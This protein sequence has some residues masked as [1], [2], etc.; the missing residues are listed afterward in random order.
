M[1]NESASSPGIRHE[2]Y[3]NL[4]EDPTSVLEVTKA[5]LENQAAVVSD[6][7]EFV[8]QMLEYQT[9]DVDDLRIRYNESM[10][11]HSVDSSI[12]LEGPKKASYI[13]I[14]GLLNETKSS[15]TLEKDTPRE[16]RTLLEMAWDQRTEATPTR[17]ALDEVAS[18]SGAKAAEFVNKW[19][20]SDSEAEVYKDFLTLK[21]SEFDKVEKEIIKAT[22]DISRLDG[23][24]AVLGGGGVEA[25]R[26]KTE[27]KEH[28]K[29]TA[30]ADLAAEAEETE[31]WA[32]EAEIQK[33]LANV[34][35]IDEKEWGKTEAR[36]RSLY[37]E[38]DDINLDLDDLE[39][40]L[41]EANN[42]RRKASLVAQRV[43]GVEFDDIPELT[44]RYDI[45]NLEDSS[46]VVGFLL[47]KNVANNV[48]TSKSE[49]FQTDYTELMDRY[50]SAQAWS[51]RAE[52]LPR[53][54]NMEKQAKKNDNL[55][56]IV[57]HLSVAIE[58]LSK[59]RALGV[60]QRL[61]LGIALDNVFE[62]RFADK[63]TTVYEL[64][65]G[66]AEKARILEIG[67]RERAR[68][69]ELGGR[70]VS[71]VEKRAA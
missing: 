15:K 69:R 8:G 11:G 22:E 58:L 49:K 71:F 27:A 6:L 7:E 56:D 48:A 19:G 3:E 66:Q 17:E 12:L 38:L 57:P 41:D 40:V 68:F 39:L 24:R 62:M 59:P 37:P 18:V 21:E 43:L 2:N 30:A 44:S 20:L 9:V 61:N 46:W 65:R 28:S 23:V 47:R 54:M 32:A 45:E 1:N 53:L 51:H 36:L 35:E 50:V 25:I 31:K 52:V 16:L 67:D 55:V 13:N 5:A 64:Q 60:R 29:E 14:A 26:T 42:A 63:P 34:A 10:L 4:Q 33:Q 70:I